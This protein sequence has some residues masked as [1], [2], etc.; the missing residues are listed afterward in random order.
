MQHQAFTLSTNERMLHNEKNIKI[1]RRNGKQQTQNHN[2][3]KSSENNRTNSPRNGGKKG[4]MTR[5]KMQIPAKTIP[6]RK[7]QKRTKCET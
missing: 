2:S 7:Q 1:S 6:E 5:K 3:K 4:I